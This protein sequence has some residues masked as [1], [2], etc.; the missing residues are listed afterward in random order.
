MTAIDD[1]T[2]ERA[3]DLAAAGFNGLA[4]VIVRVFPAASPPV[5]ELEVHFHNE[6]HRDTLVAAANTPDRAASIFPLR[7]GHRIR[8]GAASGQIHTSAVAPGPT[9]ASLILQVTPIGDYSTYELAVDPAAIDPALALPAVRIDPFFA[10]LSFRFR[11]GCFSNAFAPEWQAAPAP[12]AA[13]HIDY[14][15]KDY[16]SFRHTLI[17]AMMQRVPGWQ[18]TSE[19]DL[20]QVII[21]L[22]A[23]TGDELS[24]YQDRVMNE[25]WLSTARS[26]VSLARHARLM[27]Y[28]IHQGNQADTWIALQ[29]DRAAVTG[30]LKL[31]A[32]QPFW[33]GAQARPGLAHRHPEAVIFATRI[34]HDLHPILDA[35]Q[36]YTWDDAVPEL[37][38]GATRADLAV[39]VTGLGLTELAGVQLVADFVN[40][41]GPSTL[42]LRHLLVEET[43]NPLTGTANGRDPNRRQL[44]ELIEGSAQVIEDPVRGRHLVRLRW[45]DEDRLRARYAFTVFPGGFRTPGACLFHG[46]LARVHHGHFATAIFHEPGQELAPDDLTNPS[47]PLER[48]FQRTPGDRYGLLCHLPHAPLAYLPTPPGGEAPP[49][50]TLRVTVEVPFGGADD[51]DEV[52]SLIHSDDSQE[53]GD[54]FAVE[55]DEHQRS[56]IRFGN[57][58]NGRL[59]PELSKITCRYQVGQGHVGNIGPDTLANAE[60]VPPIV[61]PVITRCWNPFDVT[62]GRDP[63]LPEKILRNAP[64]AARAR[65]LRAVTTADYVRRA[66]EVPGVSRAAATYL[67]TGS[68]RTV[69]IA[70]D[71]EGTTVLSD[72]LRAAVA[73]HLETVRLIGED[74]ELRAPRY[75]AVALTVVVCLKQDF[76]PAD[77]RHVLEQEFS[78]GYTPDGR[79]GFFHPDRWTF[80]QRLRKSEIAGRIHRV[81]GVGHIVHMALVRFNQPTPGTYADTT[82]GPDELFIGPDEIVRVG[83]EPGRLENGFVRFH[84]QGGRQ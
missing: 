20:D 25:A 45:R 40:G 2:Q 33:T 19:A 43:L 74:L 57:N 9:P 32:G 44:L 67:W 79:A 80:G 27:D 55:T 83:N 68:W 52:I 73:R 46:N 56:L 75:V 22:I 37:A 62:G 59:P 6:L 11:P 53:D 38:A 31:P 54:H 23:A 66:E 65:Q 15:A 10:E 76:W 28:H 64:E 51:W 84:L 26:R 81:A 69:R 5:A 60:S 41:T 1:A 13:P 12:Q 78:D 8:A 39:D 48:H 63:E 82:A 49:R 58:T 50:S 16:D 71:P 35:L 29:L 34:D 18:A 42:R 47:A 77:V 3:N 61:T 70:I 14:L 7:G 72:S 4:R 30:L 21:G 24:D 36:L 17:S